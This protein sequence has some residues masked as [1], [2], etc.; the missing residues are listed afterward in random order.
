MSV[1]NIC[2]DIFTIFT[3]LITFVIR[4]SSYR[5]S[6]RLLLYDDHPPCPSFRSSTLRILNIRLQ[7]FDD[8]L[9]LL[10]GRFNQLHTLIVDLAHLD[11]PDEILNPVN[12]VRKIFVVK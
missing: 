2:N 6:I 5:N 7:T 8:C 9:Y 10:D 3:D 11:R 12:F 4:D 1:R